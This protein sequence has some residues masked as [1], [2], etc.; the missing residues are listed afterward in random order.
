MLAVAPELVDRDE[1]ARADD[2]DRTEGLVFRYTAPSLSTNG[3]TGRPSEA[4]PELGETLVARTADA[5]AELVA[6]G[7]VEEPPL[8]PA[9]FPTLDGSTTTATPSFTPTTQGST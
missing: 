3:V 9:P 1:M 7:R 2:P 8:G 4:T 5:L 6:R